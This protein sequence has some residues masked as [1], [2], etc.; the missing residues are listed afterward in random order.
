M[1]GSPGGSP[2]WRTVR[3]NVRIRPCTARAPAAL[4][5]LCYVAV[6]FVTGEDPGNKYC[7]PAC[8]AEPLR[9]CLWL[10]RRGP[11]RRTAPVAC[12]PCALPRTGT[13]SALPIDLHGVLPSC[14]PFQSTW[15]Y[16]LSWFFGFVFNY[17][18][19]ILRESV[20]GWGWGI[21]SSLH[22]QHPARFHDPWDHD[23]S[24]NRQESD[25]RNRLSP[26]AA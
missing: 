12:R 22:T 4:G 10:A 23:L 17:Y 19:L 6:G 14:P 2:S 7:S 8:I 1:A 24:R 26:P 20:A 9:G 16:T 5:H 11:T 15:F 3:A 25:T 18:F 13:P 21:P